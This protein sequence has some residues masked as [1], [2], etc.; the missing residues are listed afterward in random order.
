MIIG[1]HILYGK[2][3]NLDKPLITLQK[4]RT[5]ASNN[6]H[7]EGEMMDLDIALEVKTEYDVKAIIRKKII[8]K[9]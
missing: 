8:F 3:L 1:H 2:V 9:T 6:I 7:S 5:D 4:K